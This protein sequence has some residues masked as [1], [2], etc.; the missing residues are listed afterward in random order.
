[1]IRG[2]DIIPKSAKHELIAISISFMIAASKFILKA[3]KTS[4][5]MLITEIIFL[6]I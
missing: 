3:C 6:T 5:I 4:K 2:V 1:V